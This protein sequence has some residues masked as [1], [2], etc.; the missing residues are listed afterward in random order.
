MKLRDII[1][2]VRVANTDQAISLLG[3]AARRL[4]GKGRRELPKRLASVTPQEAN[5]THHGRRGQ[6]CKDCIFFEHRKGR[7]GDTLTKCKIVK[8]RVSPEGTCDYFRD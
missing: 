6:Q 5:Y 3:T 8:A 1:N 7:K 2:E 4:F